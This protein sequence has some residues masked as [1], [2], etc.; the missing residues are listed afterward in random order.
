MT[1]IKI[2]NYAAWT[3]WRFTFLIYLYSVD[4]RSTIWYLDALK[5]SIAG[6]RSTIC[7]ELSY[8]EFQWILSPSMAAIKDYCLYRGLCVLYRSCQSQVTHLSER[9]QGLSLMTV[10]IS[11]IL[12]CLRIC[13]H[14]WTTVSN[15]C[16]R[17]RAVHSAYPIRMKYN[18][19]TCAFF[20]MMT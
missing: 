10:Q 18:S 13:S 12:P 20:T 16:F 15:Y 6:F 19:K 11:P 8:P 14:L 7:W 4:T 3:P 5:I 1:Y 9:V 2:I 17:T